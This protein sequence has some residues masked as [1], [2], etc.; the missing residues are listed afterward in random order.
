MV[1]DWVMYHSTLCHVPGEV[2][3]LVAEQHT[4][5]SQKAK[6]RDPSSNEPFTGASFLVIHMKT[7]FVIGI[8]WE[9]MEQIKGG[10]FP[11]TPELQTSSI[12]ICT[13]YF[14][15]PFVRVDQ[16]FIKTPTDNMAL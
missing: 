4:D 11:S 1:R 3:R 5:V 15:Y 14:S 6:V 12:Y 8:L 16:I 9:F 7:G 13:P 10:V 2:A